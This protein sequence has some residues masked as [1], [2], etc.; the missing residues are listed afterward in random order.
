MHTNINSSHGYIVLPAALPGLLLPCPVLLAPPSSRCEE[1]HQFRP[2]ATPSLPPV[3]TYMLLHLSYLCQSHPWWQVVHVGMFQTPSTQHPAD[4]LGL[5]SHLHDMW[6]VRMCTK[7]HSNHNRASITFI[8][9]LACRVRGWM[10]CRTDEMVCW[11]LLEPFLSANSAYFNKCTYKEVLSC[12]QVDYFNCRFNDYSNCK[13][14]CYSLS[15][16]HHMH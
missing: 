4:E 3:A 11:I 16:A 8:H 1:G 6:K 12:M 2:C 9:T 10:E 7:L 15:S 13:L 5:G 14:K